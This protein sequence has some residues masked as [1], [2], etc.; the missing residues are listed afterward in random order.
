MLTRILSTQLEKKDKYDTNSNQTIFV[1]L[2]TKDKVK[3]KIIVLGANIGLFPLYEFLLLTMF[4]Q[5]LFLREKEKEKGLKLALSL[6]LTE[7]D[8]SL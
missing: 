2:L 7:E 6:I 5:H 8:K 3:Q 4:F 1:K